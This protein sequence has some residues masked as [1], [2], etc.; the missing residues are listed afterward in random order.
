MKK[1]KKFPP[2]KSKAILKIHLSLKY[3]YKNT[4]TINFLLKIISPPCA[5]AQHIYLLGEDLIVGL[6]ISTHE[7]LLHIYISLQIAYKCIKH[8]GI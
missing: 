3:S 5:G 6:I 1:R 4:H 8:I 7:V 2:L